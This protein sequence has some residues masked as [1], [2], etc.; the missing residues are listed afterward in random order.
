M[1]QLLEMER[2]RGSRNLQFVR[3]RPRRKRVGRAPH[4]QPEDS[5]SRILSERGESSNGML[6]FH[7][8]KDM[9]ISKMVNPSFRFRQLKLKTD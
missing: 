4:Q 9:E 5:E 7:I 1:H 2:E 8:S 6:N 3:N